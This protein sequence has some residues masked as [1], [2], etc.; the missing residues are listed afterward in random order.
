MRKFKKLLFIRVG[1]LFINI[2][3]QGQII[4]MCNKTIPE[5]QETAKNQWFQDAKF[6]LF[7]YWRLF[8]QHVGKWNG[9]RYYDISEWVMNRGKIP[10]ADYR[11]LSQ[12]F[13]PSKINADGWVKLANEAGIKYIVIT[14]K[15]HE[16]F[17][18]FDS[19][20]YDLN[21]MNTLFHR[22]SLKELSEACNKAGVKLSFYYSQFLDWHEFNGGGNDW[23]FVEK[24]K[25]YKAY[26]NSKSIPH[27]ME[28]LYNYAPFGST[29]FEMSG[30][31][32]KEGTHTLIDKARNIQPTYLRSSRVGCLKTIKV[33]PLNECKEFF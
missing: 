4:V 14:T 26:Y 28:L 30:G 5:H 32:S 31:H 20:V 13:N 21:I 7:V 16:G 12:E 17:A 11:N 33:S 24:N 6:G 23:N 9:K 19:K 29:W 15:H 22:D 25:E 1:I 3:T 27:I 2:P 10:V 8:A 18:M